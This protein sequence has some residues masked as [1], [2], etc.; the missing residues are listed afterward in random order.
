M[1]ASALWSRM[2]AEGWPVFYGFSDAVIRRPAD[3]SRSLRVTGYWW[4]SRAPGWRPPPDLQQF[5]DAGPAPVFVGLG[6]RNLG[7]PARVAAVIRSALHRAGLRGV[8]QTGWAGLSLDD[9]IITIGET[10]H[11]WLFPRMAAVAHHC[12]AGTTAAGLRA[13]VP[14]VG[15]PVLADQPFWASRLV[16][17][18]ASPA[19]IPFGRLSADRLADALSATVRD[20]GFGHRARRLSH[21]LNSDDGA[22]QVARALGQ[23]T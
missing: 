12:G 14:T 8:V 19:S 23:F 7:D 20:D 13:G 15:I 2:D 18:G 4:P 11:E 16:A 21:A 6:S 22:G 9:D 5:L 1:R 3:W 10:P 17:L